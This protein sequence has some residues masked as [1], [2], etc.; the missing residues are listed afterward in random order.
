M[1]GTSPVLGVANADARSYRG[2][3]TTVDLEAAAWRIAHSGYSVEAAFAAFDQL[4]R[5]QIAYVVACWTTLDPATG[6]FTTTTLTG[7]PRDRATEKR[8]MSAS[9]GSRSRRTSSLCLS[10]PGPR[11][12]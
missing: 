2:N 9:S 4:L 11:P 10:G 3:V 7:A 6:L 5:S 12:F 1:A 8:L